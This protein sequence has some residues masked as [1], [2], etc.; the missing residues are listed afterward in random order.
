M[1][2]L[3]EFNGLIDGEEGVPL[4]QVVQ[5]EQAVVLQ[6]FLV[7]ECGGEQD[8]VIVGQLEYDVFDVSDIGFDAL[9]FFSFEIFKT[10]P[11]M[12]KPIPIAAVM[13]SNCLCWPWSSTKL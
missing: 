12:E 8:L 10:H 5:V 7:F 2:D 1:L 4:F 13:G 11:V 9:H 3:G 6:N